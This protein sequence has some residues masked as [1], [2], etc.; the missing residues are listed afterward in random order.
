MQ[1]TLPATEQ[2]VKRL[3]AGAGIEDDGLVGPDTWKVLRG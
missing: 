3:Q 1:L 2:A